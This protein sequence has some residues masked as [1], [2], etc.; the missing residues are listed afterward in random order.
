M[1]KN[2][3]GKNGPKANTLLLTQNFHPYG[4][5]LLN[6]EVREFQY[7]SQSK[8]LVSTALFMISFSENLVTS[9]LVDKEG[10]Q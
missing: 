4:A 10:L 5:R 9:Y 2:S 6:I 7:Q 1:Q 8:V 3:N